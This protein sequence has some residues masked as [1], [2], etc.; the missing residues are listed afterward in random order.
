MPTL[1]NEAYNAKNEPAE[2]QIIE[3]VKTP[4]WNDLDSHLKQKYNIQPQLFFSNCS[5]DKGYW[6]G[7]NVKYKKSS[8]SLC[9]LYPKEGYFLALIPVSAKDLDEAE[10]LI[11]LCDKYTQDLYHE[12]KP[13]NTGKF[14]AMEVKNKKILR[15]LKNFVAL[16]IS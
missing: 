13:G 8:K 9:T 11:K 10:I 15:D 6:K 2:S 4:L 1:W 14:L 7:W 5:M 16:R 3:F 12:A